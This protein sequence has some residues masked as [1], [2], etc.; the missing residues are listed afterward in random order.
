MPESNVEIVRR[1]YEAW[2]R[3]DFDAAAEVLDPQIEWQMPSNIP[4]AG[5]YRGPDEDRRRLEE[6]LEAWDEF[7]V[8]VEELIDEGDRV[9]ARIRYG[10]LGS[11]SGIEVRGASADTHVWTLRDGRAIRLEMRGGTE[12]AAKDRDDPE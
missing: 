1:A 7:T 10:G 12:E 3:G 4:D 5:T 8:D 11:G 6:F 2:N 9:I